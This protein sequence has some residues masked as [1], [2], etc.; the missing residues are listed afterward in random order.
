MSVE[1]E[2]LHSG[3]LPPREPGAITF[4]NVTF[5]YSTEHPILKNVSFTIPAN[6]KTAI[7]GENGCGKS[8]ILKLIQGFYQ[9]D[10]GTIAIDGLPLKDFQLHQLRRQF[11]Y[12]LQNTPLFS[13]TIRDNI[14]YGF[15]N[16][17]AEDEVIAAAKQ[18]GLCSLWQTADRRSYT[19]P[20]I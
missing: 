6:Q 1:E 2:P 15:E 11:A 4:Q 17:V 7:I 20:I 3:K 16:P 5:G 9:A 13:G 10:S 18:A 19:F 12:V 14:T 8:T